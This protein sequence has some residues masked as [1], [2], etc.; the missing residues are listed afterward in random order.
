MESEPAAVASAGGAAPKLDEFLGLERGASP[1]A[2][3]GVLESLL[4]FSWDSAVP[5]EGTNQP[6]PIAAS[7]QSGGPE[8]PR[9][10]KGEVAPLAGG[11]SLPALADLVSL[12]LRLCAADRL[13]RAVTE[14]AIPI[15]RFEWSPGSEPVTE[16]AV[17]VRPEPG[18]LGAEVPVRLAPLPRRFVRP[19]APR[20]IPPPEPIRLPPTPF[21]R[22]M[23]ARFGAMLAVGAA[24]FFP[25]WLA[26]ELPAQ[27]SMVSPTV[28]WALAAV[29]PAES[30][31][32]SV[33]AEEPEPPLRIQAPQPWRHKWKGI[34]AAQVRKR[35]SNRRT[36]PVAARLEVA[37]PAESAAPAAPAESFR[38]LDLESEVAKPVSRPSA[39]AQR[40]IRPGAPEK[41]SGKI[42]PSASK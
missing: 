12:E 25:A 18:G 5:L 33:A 39:P 10:G 20:F 6:P 23:V 42:P 19:P 38:D 28:A 27:G 35:P 36:H 41:S 9:E 22:P 37:V 26:L 31:E 15:F 2:A 3:P 30:T 17:P 8:R 11:D 24:A 13:A 1:S 14:P 40:V 7:V 16:P 29:E 32:L 21:W 4:A 34:K